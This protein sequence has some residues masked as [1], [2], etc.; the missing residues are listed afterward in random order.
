MNQ[1]SPKLD[2][3]D[4]KLLTYLEMDARISHSELAKKLKTS[5]QVVKYRIEKLEKQG[6]IQG[7]FALVDIAKLGKKPYLIYLKLIKISSKAEIEWVK[8]IDKNPN[9]IATGKNAGNWDLTLV[10]SASDNNELDKILR[11]ILSGK[12][13][14]I[15]QKLI[16]DQIQSTYFT[17]KLLYNLEGKEA[18]TEDKKENLEI[19]EKEQLLLKLL[20][21]NCRLSLLELSEKIK[22]SPNTIKNK[23]KSLE[24]RKI[25]IGYKTKINYEKLSFLHF[26]VFL[27]LKKLTPEFYEQ[28]KT[29]L[30]NKGNAESVSRC[31]GYADI[32]F[33][34]HTKD[35]IELYSLISEIK[36]KFLQNIINIDSM[37]IFGWESINYYKK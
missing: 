13:D 19:D 15:K 30:K 5:K 1:E 31:I 22:T 3:K 35:I 24:Q 11:S 18:S 36:D 16:T 20:S 12:A 14:K 27:H 25:I 4:K 6:I 2:L 37:I 32:D 34:C 8:Q 26:R 10:I 33:R 21:Q 7:Y 28:V 23:I 17:S 9:V 29:F